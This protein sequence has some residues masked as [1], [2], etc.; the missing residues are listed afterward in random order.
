LSASS[1]TR[2]R[3]PSGPWPIREKVLEVV[4]AQEHDIMMAVQERDSGPDSVNKQHQHTDFTLNDDDK[5]R[6]GSRPARPGKDR[7]QQGHD[8]ARSG[9]R[10]MRATMRPG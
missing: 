9:S 10:P 2:P 5:A 1:C 6:G 4:K 8:D 3:T 7:D